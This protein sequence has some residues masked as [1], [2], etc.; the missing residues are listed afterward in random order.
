MPMGPAR[1][2][3]TADSVAHETARSV[4][5]EIGGWL[6]VMRCAYDEQGVG[7]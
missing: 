6:P 4:A 7:V 5:H 3:W 1:Q 2:A